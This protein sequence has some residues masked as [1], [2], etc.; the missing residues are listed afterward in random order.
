[1][2]PVVAQLNVPFSTIQRLRVLT[3]PGLE[4]WT[5]VPRPSLSNVAPR[6]AAS[7]DAFA[8]NVLPSA[9]WT[10][11]VEPE[12]NAYVLDAVIVSAA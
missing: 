5:N 12:S 10:I 8:V 1:M 3:T 9:T 4:F 2:F 7:I 6:D 11:P